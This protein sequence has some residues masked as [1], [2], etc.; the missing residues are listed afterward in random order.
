ML[1]TYF[2]ADA[3]RPAFA[4][5]PTAPTRAVNPASPAAR[6]TIDALAVLAHDIRGPLANLAL[7]IEAIGAEARRHGQTSTAGQ[8]AKAERTIERLDAMM[9]AMLDR[10][11]RSGDPLAARAERVDLVEL[12]ETAVTLNRPRAEKYEVRLHCLVAAPMTVI[13]DGHLLIQAVDNLL[14]NAITFTRAGGR[15]LC[16][17]APTEDG[18]V[19]VRITDEGPGLTSDD[20]GR[21]FRPFAT[22]SGQAPRPRKSTGLGLAIVRQIAESH[23][24]SI[25][26]E[27]RGHGTGAT[28]TLRLP[29]ADW[30]QAADEL[31]RRSKV[32]AAGQTERSTGNYGASDGT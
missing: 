19:V 28:F 10:A 20:L 13:G 6:G 15:V 14:G 12:L 2:H 26:A 8:A 4:P 7:L 27:S 11:R 16:E 24:G 32:A 30:G 18:G 29:A 23:G 17:V 3:I 21:L 25:T 9:T 22:L 1:A 5:R 31:R